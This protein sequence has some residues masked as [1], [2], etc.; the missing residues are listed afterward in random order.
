MARVPEVASYCQLLLD[1]LF[2]YTSYYY[3]PEYKIN[4]TKLHNK[5]NKTFMDMLYSVNIVLHD[6]HHKACRYKRYK[7]TDVE[8]LRETVSMYAM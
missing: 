2:Y 4:I 1:V 8:R 6:I 5:I 7:F 3:K